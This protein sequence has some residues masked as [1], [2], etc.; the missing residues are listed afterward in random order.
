M[1]NRFCA[2]L[3]RALHSL[4][5][6]RTD[7]ASRGLHALAAHRGHATHHDHLA[8]HRAAIDLGLAAATASA[9]RARRASGTWPAPTADRRSRMAVVME[10][11]GA[12]LAWE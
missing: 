7:A 2:L 11:G 6:L 4:V 9:R 8:H 3:P 1:L 10:P 5:R 12:M